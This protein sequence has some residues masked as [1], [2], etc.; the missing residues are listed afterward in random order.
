MKK[1]LFNSLCLFS[2]LSLAFLANTG[3]AQPK[4]PV[5]SPADS[6]SGK[7][8]KANIEIKY[9][10]PSVKG[11]KIWGELV[12]YDQVWRAGAN[13]ATTFS[14]DKAVSVEGKSLPAGT[15]SFFLLPNAEG[16]W[17]AI[18]NKVAKQWGA[19]KYDQSQ[20]ALRVA[21]KPSKT[22]SLQERLVYE[23]TKKGFQL[24]WEH[25]VVPV[26]VK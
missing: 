6:V 20:D 15:Y 12:P 2:F 24:K 8:G 3:F 11:R 1:L 19:Y 4:K 16:S 7:V 17:T 23:I 22:S 25:T 9:N 13:G 21:V 5:A 26:S 10:S 18:F 14:T